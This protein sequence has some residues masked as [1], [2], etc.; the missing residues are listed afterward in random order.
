M[1]WAILKNEYDNNHH[2]WEK[3]CSKLN[4]NCEI[5]D[6]TKEDWLKK[7]KDFNYD[8]YL[9]CPPGRESLYKSLYDERIYIIAKVMKKYCYPSYDEIKIHENK[10]YLS[11][12]LS[13]NN[14]PHPRTFV[15]YDKVEALSFIKD[16]KLPIV[17]KFNIGASGK[18][19]K[20]FY[21]KLSIYKYLDAAFNK[22][23]RQNWG[24]NIKMG[25]FRER[26]LKLLL[27]PSRILNRIQVYTKVFNE[28]QRGYVIFQEYIPHKYEWRIVKIG[29]SFFGHQ[30]IKTGEKASGTKGIDY[31]LPDEKQLTFVKSLCDEYGFNSMAVD[32]FEDNDGNLIINELQTIFGHVQSYI[33]EKEGK[34]GRLIYTNTGWNFEE[35]MFNT[36]LSYDLRLESAIKLLSIK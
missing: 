28:I 32:A 33:C 16:Y 10:R 29:E 2:H 19:V 25:S 17:A 24:P 5:I 8:G 18:G 20:I 14:I 34:P 15:F 26:L 13:A 30:K 4:Q 6:L 23:I 11:Y 21:D 9:T 36:N 3:A 7:I 27:H 1:Q 22:G 31:V 12:W 35:G